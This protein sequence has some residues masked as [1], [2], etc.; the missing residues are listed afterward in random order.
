MP[1]QEIFPFPTSLTQAKTILKKHAFVNIKEYLAIRAELGE[2]NGTQYS[3]E[4]IR[5]DILELRLPSR[6][7]LKK[8]VQKKLRQVSAL[9][10]HVLI[11]SLV[12]P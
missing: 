9:A 8:F 1:T 5:R 4:R 3:R 11:C 2:E 6:S 10:D 12:H 7:A